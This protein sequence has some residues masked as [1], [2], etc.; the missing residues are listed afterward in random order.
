MDVRGV[1]P[2]KLDDLRRV[3]HDVVRTDRL[4]PE[5]LDADAAAAD[6]GIP[7]EHAGGEGLAADL[8]PAGRVDEEAEHVLLASVQAGRP[9]EAFRR[10]LETNGEFLDHGQQIGVEKPGVAGGV[11]RAELAAEGEQLQGLRSLRKGFAEHAGRGVGRKAIDGVLGHARQSAK[12]AKRPIVHLE[13]PVVAGVEHQPVA[14]DRPDV[15][16]PRGLPDFQS[17]LLLPLDVLREHAER[18]EALVRRPPEEFFGR[19]SQI[20]GLLLG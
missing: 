4:E 7:D 11:D 14:S 20:H 6:L 18:R 19:T 16:G 1:F 17:L 15:Q 5:S 8:G 12:L 2:R 13:G 10:G 3:P 9:V